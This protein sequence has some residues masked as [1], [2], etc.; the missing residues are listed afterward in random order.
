M[1]A[2]FTVPLAREANDR[3]PLLAS[4]RGDL[5]ADDRGAL[6]GLKIALVP[7]QGVPLHELFGIR[8]AIR[9]ESRTLPSEI[10]LLV[11]AER[12]G[13]APEIIA[14]ADHAAHIP[15]QSHSLNAAMAA[16]VALYELRIRMAGG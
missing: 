5:P 10:T 7:G 11:G 6:P 3:W 8:S 1:G 2:V 16:T 4:D 13:L 9:D 14:A 15:I 12:E